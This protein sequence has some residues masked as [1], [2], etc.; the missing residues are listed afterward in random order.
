MRSKTLNL[1]WQHWIVHTSKQRRNEDE[2]L[3]VWEKQ[4]HFQRLFDRKYQS[5]FTIILVITRKMTKMILQLQHSTTQRIMDNWL[6]ANK[7]ATHRNWMWT[8][9]RRLRH[10]VNRP[11]T[12]NDRNCVSFYDRNFMDKRKGIKIERKQ[13]NMTKKTERRWK[14]WEYTQ[15]TENIGTQ[16]TWHWIVGVRV[17]VCACMC[18]ALSHFIVSLISFNDAVRWLHPA[19][20]MEQTINRN[21]KAKEFLLTFSSSP[22][23]F[24]IPLFVRSFVLLMQLYKIY[25]E[26]IK[27]NM[28]FSIEWEKK[29]LNVSMRMLFCTEKNLYPIPSLFRI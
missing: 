22:F 14:L 15:Q 11:N 1:R 8:I 7:I 9:N 13:D 24:F 4:E 25:I 27:R 5:R 17:R 26:M 28:K 12:R 29:G 3:A 21:D 2:S 19:D 18:M 6:M 20:W 10:R 23:P 16:G